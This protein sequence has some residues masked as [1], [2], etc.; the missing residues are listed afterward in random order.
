MAERNLTSA[1]TAPQWDGRRRRQ[2]RKPRRRPERRGNNNKKKTSLEAVMK[3]KQ[4]KC[5][6]FQLHHW[7]EGKCQEDKRVTYLARCFY[8]CSWR[9]CR[10]AVLSCSRPSLSWWTTASG[11]DHNTSTPQR[12]HHFSVT[13]IF[14][15][16]TQQVSLNFGMTL[17]TINTV[18]SEWHTDLH[19]QHKNSAVL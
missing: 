3:T 6:Q 1:S 18:T 10:A 4:E 5:I 14:E 11:S 19:K 15:H 13:Y 16:T 8:T 12:M 9:C 2:R 7:D 17:Q